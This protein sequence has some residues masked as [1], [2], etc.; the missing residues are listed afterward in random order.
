MENDISD[1][2]RRA[3]TAQSGCR[4]FERRIGICGKNK[5]EK[6]RILPPRSS[7]RS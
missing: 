7:L 1:D 4:E 6:L 5:K 3:G 2:E